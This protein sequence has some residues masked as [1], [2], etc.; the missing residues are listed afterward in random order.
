M[1]ENE[2]R[3]KTP[4]GEMLTF[5]ALDLWRRNLQKEPAIAGA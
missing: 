1:I 5:I 3:I 4:D 2:I